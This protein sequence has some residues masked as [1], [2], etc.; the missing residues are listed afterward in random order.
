MMNGKEDAWADLE[1]RSCAL[2][3]K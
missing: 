2:K 3:I 1:L